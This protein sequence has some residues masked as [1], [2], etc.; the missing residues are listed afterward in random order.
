MIRNNEIKIRL[1]QDEFDKLNSLVKATGLSREE[2][3]RMLIKNIVPSN[4]PSAE[5]IEVIKQLRMIGNNI[6]QIVVIA[7]KTGSIDI[8]KYKMTYQ[9]LQDS[10]MKIFDIINESKKLEVH[11]GNNKDMGSE[12]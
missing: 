9:N 5:F 7:Y 8:M 1:S 10:I 12:G 4:T 11:N 2:Y 6:N 3:L